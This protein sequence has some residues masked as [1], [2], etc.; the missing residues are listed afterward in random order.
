LSS[1]QKEDWAVYLTKFYVAEVGIAR[2]LISLVTTP[3]QLRLINI[4][5][6]IKWV[7]DSQ[8]IKLSERQIEAVR[9]SINSK[10]MVITG[11]PGT[12]KTTIIN[13]VIK[14]YKKMGQKILLAAPTGRAA[15]RMAETTGHE[16]KTLHRLL[17][18]TPGS[19][20]F[21]RNE[22][23]PL[24]ADLIIIDETSMVDSQLMYHFLK[25]VSLKATLI[26]VGDVDQLPSVGAGCV[27]KDIINSK[28]ITI[29]VLDQIFRQSRESMIVVNA[30][31]I[32][33]GDLPIFKSDETRL[34][35]FYFFFIE[36]PEKVL[37][38]II[39]LCRD[40]IP[41]R[42]HFHPLEDIQVLTPMHKGTVG[43]ASLN[44]AL[45]KELNIRKEEIMRGGK[46]FKVGD[47]VIQLRNN[48]DKD[49]YNGD[50]GRVV[51]I[52]GETQEM[53]VDY[54]GR[55]VKY[56]FF[57]LDEVVLAYAISVH[58]SQGS[59]YPVV[60]IPV[61]TQHYMLLQRNLLYTGITRGKKLVILIG[62]KKA[63]AIAINNNK[64][65]KR[66]TMLKER[67]MNQ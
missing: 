2:Q 26:L 27:L 8:N 35:D 65:Q 45:Q 16:A 57:E 52:D 13:S 1:S 3:K 14:I 37:E 10:V 58:K 4:D 23:N 19:G 56:E 55:R 54:D 33:K 46:V 64:P 60:I 43:V 21:K 51:N 44:T 48:Y 9:D 41:A 42:F 18:Y 66:Y 12:G 59:E 34:K 29:V 49:V 50:I 17:E 6:A 32:N 63:L 25:A 39:Q 11:G 31:R 67:L 20:S 28:R 40:I 53:I 47:K 22:T 30:H 61:L 24:D 38:K 5:Q 15:K 7:Q 36:D 62:T